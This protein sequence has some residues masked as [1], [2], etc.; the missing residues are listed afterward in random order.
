MR[1]RSALLGLI[2]ALALGTFAGCGSDDKDAKSSSSTVPSARLAASAA[3]P[4]LGFYGGVSC[5]GTDAFCDGIVTAA[6]TKITAFC[7][8]PTGV[9]N[10]DMEPSFSSGGKEYPYVCFRLKAA[11]SLEDFFVGDTKIVT[12]VHVSSD[13]FPL[14][15]DNG[16]CIEGEWFSTRKV[17]GRYRNPNNVY[18][19]W[20]AVWLRS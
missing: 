19:P 20:R 4:K 17:S 9:P 12:S 3:P 1:T 14:T 11:N 10:P 8:T 15:C 13:R 18:A 6:Q 16:Y 5:S 7:A 2:A